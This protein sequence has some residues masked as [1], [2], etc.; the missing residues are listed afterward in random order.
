MSEEELASLEKSVKLPFKQLQNISL[1]IKNSS[2][3]IL[4]RWYKVLESLLLAPCMMPCD[5]ATR[6]NSTYNMLEFSD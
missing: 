4:P 2:T 3:I 5:V 6:W 1:A